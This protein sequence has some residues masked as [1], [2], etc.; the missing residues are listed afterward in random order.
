L[1]LPRASLA[2]ALVSFNVGVECGQLCI[3]LLALPLLR[4]LRRIRAFAPAASICILAL[5]SFWAVAR[6]FS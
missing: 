2:S 1:H 4:R 6:L 3:V 5:G